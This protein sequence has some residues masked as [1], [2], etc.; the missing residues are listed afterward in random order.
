MKFIS[1]SKTWKGRG[2]AF[3]IQLLLRKWDTLL[4]IV[5]WNRV[6]YIGPHEPVPKYTNTQMNN[7][8]NKH[9]ELSLEGMAAC[10]LNVASQ[11]TEE[12]KDRKCKWQNQDDKNLCDCP[13]LPDTNCS[14]IGEGFEWCSYYKERQ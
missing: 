1:T 5:F 12:E 9:P 11:M 7:R 3:S 8:Q 13:H 14:F 2:I 4:I 6:L 10:H